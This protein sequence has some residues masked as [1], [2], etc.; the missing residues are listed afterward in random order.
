MWEDSNDAS[1]CVDLR[2]LIHIYLCREPGDAVVGR[3][4]RGGAVWDDP[5]DAGVEVAV[6]GRPRLRKLR[7][8]EDE[9]M[10]SGG[11]LFQQ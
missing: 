9:A 6:A 4:R 2:V 8:N 5:D 1:V 3:K 11:F 10:L 7:H